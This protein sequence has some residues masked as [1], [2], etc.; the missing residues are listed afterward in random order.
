MTRQTANLFDRRRASPPAL[1]SDH[2]RPS[3]MTDPLSFVP[4]ALAAADG[5]IDGVPCRRLVA[6]GVALLQRTVPLV[7]AL[8]GRRAAILLPPGPAFVVALSACAGRTALL[9]DSADDHV[10]ISDALRAGDVGAVLTDR[11]LSDRLPFDMPRL[12]LDDAPSRAEWSGAAATRSIDLSLHA[13][14]LLEG[15]PDTEGSDEIALLV[16]DRPLASNDALQALSHRALLDAARVTV[17]AQRLDHRTHALCLASPARTTAIVAGLLAPLI[18]GG[19]VSSANGRD[20]A[21]VIA[22]IE[23]DTV[24]SLVAPA[25]VYMAIAGACSARGRALD[26]PLLQHCVVSDAPPDPALTDR[27]R[28]VCAVPLQARTPHA[29]VS[30]AE[31]DRSAT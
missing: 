27:W 24:T 13:G 12:F 5:E 18:A 9:L 10:W 3:C 4:L 2:P 15:D 11:A 1:L 6:S 28:A 23:R 29:D 7:R 22:R 14:L 16:R 21:T 26:A 20:V 30:S 19:R 8:D 17:R 25:T 31:S